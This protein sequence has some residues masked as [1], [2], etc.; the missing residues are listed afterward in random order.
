MFKFYTTRREVIESLI[1]FDTQGLPKEQIN[2]AKLKAKSEYQNKK[3]QELEKLFYNCTSDVV[4]I[5]S[6]VN[7]CDL[8]RDELEW[9]VAHCE[10]EPVN[11]FGCLED[12]DTS[13]FYSPSINWSQGGPI[14]E[15]EKINLEFIDNNLWYAKINNTEFF[16][17]GD[18]PLVAAM[19]CY[20]A[21]KLGDT[22]DLK[23]IYMGEDSLEPDDE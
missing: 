15:R 21:S 23:E 7:T 18:D 16:E 20:V 5:T 3:N 14:I 13:V 11:E 9:V 10:E 4:T 1:N 6:V 2:V 12:D 22:V 17:H 19:R 8:D